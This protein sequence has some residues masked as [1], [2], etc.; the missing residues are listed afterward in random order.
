MTT[1]PQERKQISLDLA[2]FKEAKAFAEND[3]GLTVANGLNLTHIKKMLADMGWDKPFILEASAPAPK[4]APVQE[5]QEAQTEE[6]D[7]FEDEG[8]TDPGH[9]EAEPAARPATWKGPI[10]EQVEEPKVKLMINEQ[11]GVSGKRPVFVGVNGI[12]MLIPRNEEVS[13]KLRYLNALRGA[14]ET[15][16]ELNEQTQKNEPKNVPSYP[17]Q[18]VEPANPAQLKKWLLW[19]AYVDAQNHVPLPKRREERD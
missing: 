13:V 2:T 19:E 16:Y 10:P 6:G 4:S 12:G 8:D 15:L 9:A 18:L 7:D 3:M 17:F 5:A 14:T 11:Q 1:E